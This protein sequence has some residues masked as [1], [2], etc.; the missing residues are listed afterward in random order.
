MAPFQAAPATTTTHRP[1]DHAAS[2]TAAAASARRGSRDF[3]GDLNRYQRTTGTAPANGSLPSSGWDRC[4]A[5]HMG[6]RRGIPLPGDYDG[7][8]Q[9][10]HC[11]VP[12]LLGVWSSSS[13]HGRLHGDWGAVAT[14]CWRIDGDPKTDIGVRPPHVD[15]AWL[16]SFG[17][18]HPPLDDWGGAEAK[19]A[20]GDYDPPGKARMKRDLRPWACRHI[21][22]FGDRDSLLMSGARRRRTGV[23]DYDGD[24]RAYCRG[25]PPVE[26]TWYMTHSSTGAT[27]LAVGIPGDRAAAETTTATV[28]R[29][30]VFRAAPVTWQVRTNTGRPPAGVGRRHEIPIPAA[31][32][33]VRYAGHRRSIATAGIWQP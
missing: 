18:R 26:G 29:T 28:E 21:V 23:G 16:H 33:I 24:H 5:G 22:Q 25:I 9:T 32:A 27:S 12:A 8:W 10:G 14:L 4:D 15:G 19:F 3:A 7:G 31:D 30:R 13:R 11:G 6:H 20:V 2:P 17:D 1:T